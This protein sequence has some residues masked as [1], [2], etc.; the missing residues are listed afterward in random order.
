MV[1]ER[2]LPPPLLTLAVVTVMFGH[3][4]LAEAVERPEIIFDN[5]YHVVFT[6]SFL[7]RSI[8]ARYNNPPTPPSA[9]DD[10]DDD[11]SVYEGYAQDGQGEEEKAKAQAASMNAY[12]IAMPVDGEEAG[13][14]PQI[15]QESHLDQGREGLETESSCAYQNLR[16]T[17]RLGKVNAAYIPDNAKNSNN[18][19]LCLNE[20]A[21][22]AENGDKSNTA[23][24]PRS[25]GV[26]FELEKDTN[27]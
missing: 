26:Y 12:S 4:H 18:E 1:S 3:F 23:G 9:P 13:R 7:S 14:S 6:D 17:A 2:V 22:C 5:L 24:D 15:G 10:D 21:M 16:E 27:S 11:E 19:Y 20:N 8:L 25:P